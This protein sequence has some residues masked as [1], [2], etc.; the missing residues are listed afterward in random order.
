[1]K[2]DS[3]CPIAQYGETPASNYGVP[4]YDSGPG[5][6]L[7]FFLAFLIS[8]KKLL[9]F[10]SELLPFRSAPILLHTLNYPFIQCCTLSSFEMGSL[11][12]RLP[13]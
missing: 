12:L 1:M 13:D 5:P 2:E 7:S 3:V 10:S 4:V 6:R 9:E 8:L 11:T